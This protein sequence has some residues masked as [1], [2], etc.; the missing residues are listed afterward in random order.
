VLVEQVEQQQLVL[1]QMVPIASFLQSLQLAVAEAVIHLTHLI[2]VEAV[3]LEALLVHK[4]VL[5]EQQT[6]VMLVVIALVQLLL[7][8]V[9]AAVEQAQLVLM[10]MVQAVAVMVVLV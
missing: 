6:K 2:Q 10:L 9:A 8:V 5:L 4:M 1:V 3:V 7:M